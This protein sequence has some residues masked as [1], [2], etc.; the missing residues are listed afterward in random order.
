MLGRPVLRQ[1]VR[2][3][4]QDSRILLATG[5]TKTSPEKDEDEGPI[6]YTSSRAA[7]WKAR[8]TFRTD[9][10]MPDAQPFSVVFSLAAF[11]IYFFILREE[12]DVDEMFDRPL[13]EVI[14]GVESTP[15]GRSRLEKK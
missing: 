12:N 5:G 14:P 4:R 8:H 6:K 2:V 9:H 1:L 7:S 13:T 15:W 11:M 3:L 10:T